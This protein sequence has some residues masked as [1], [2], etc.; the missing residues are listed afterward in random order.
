MSIICIN[1]T[2]EGEC[3]VASL[4]NQKLEYLDI[5]DSTQY[6]QKS[7]IYSANIASIEESLEAVFVNYG[8]N[9]HGFLPFKEI[10]DEYLLKPLKED[11]SRPSIND[12]LKVGQ[13]LL[14]QIEKEQRGTKGAALTTHI[15]IAGAYL[16]L[17]PTNKSGGGVSKRVEAHDRDTTRELLSQLTVPEGMSIIVRTAGVG[18]TLDEL[19]WDL[20][21]LL[22]HWNAIKHVYQSIQK[23]ALIHKESDAIIRAVRDQL[24]PNVE[25]IIVDHEPTFF[26]LSEYIQKTRPD[27]TDRLKLHA[28]SVPLFTHMQIEEQIEKLFAR[29]I[30]LASGASIVIDTTEALTAIDVNSASA[31]KADNIEDTAYR[32]NLDAA[33]EAVRQIRLRDVGGIIIIDFIDMSSKKRRNEIYNFVTEQ[34]KSDK[35]KTNIRELSDLSGI[36][37]ISRQRISPPLAESHQ[38]ICPNCNGQG[39]IRTTTGFGNMILRKIEQTAV[40]STCDLIQ[41]Q[42]PV[43]AANYILNARIDAITNIKSRYNIDI[44]IL[45]NIQLNSQKF[46]LKRIKFNAESA[47]PMQ[48]HL[49]TDDQFSIDESIPS[50]QKDK[51]QS[52]R[53]ALTTTTALSQHPASSKSTPKE[54]GIFSKLWQMIFSDTDKPA[55]ASPQK[56]KPNNQQRRRSNSGQRRKPQGN[57]ESTGNRQPSTGNRQN[58]SRGLNRSRRR[59]SDH[60][61]SN[62]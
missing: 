38:T 36:M 28:S 46:L 39:L 44:C 60:E 13:K 20:D 22:N 40:G 57:R 1:A 35:A 47:T 52:N 58:R 31:T 7:N 2:L 50:W 54:D 27:Y 12:S 18:R 48:D 10:A 42:V 23:P 55:K 43:E 15:S 24:K 17:M 11:G 41:V 51:S 32:I 8:G 61:T 34:F 14:V 56:K 29:K 4:V 21:M 53:K 49:S 3:R 9:R 5:E 19:Q 33:E 6:R 59:Q 25:Q 45:A 16:V 30:D 37:E 62:F 26:M